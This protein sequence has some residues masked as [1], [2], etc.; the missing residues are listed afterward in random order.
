MQELDPCRK[1]TLHKPEGTQHV[2][3]PRMKWLESDEEDVTNMG[4]RKWRCKRQAEDTFGR[5]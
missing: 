1:L 5:G 2:G 4:V 3:K